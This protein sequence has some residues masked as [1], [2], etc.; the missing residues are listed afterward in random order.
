MFS[1]TAARCDRSKLPQQA[2]LLLWCD[3]IARCRDVVALQ[4]HTAKRRASLVG[5]ACIWLYFVLLHCGA[6]LDLSFV[7]FYGFA[8]LSLSIFVVGFLLCVLL[9]WFYFC[10]FAW[11]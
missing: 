6:L 8:L 1:L 4:A 10:S 3:N 9:L 2:A 7:C 5:A 11:C